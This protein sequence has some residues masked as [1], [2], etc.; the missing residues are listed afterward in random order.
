MKYS[1][2]SLMIVV[3]LACVYL[4]SYSATLTPI[5]V[6]DEGW[7][8]MVVSGQR[9][10]RF[11]IFDGVLQFVFLPVIWCDRVVRPGYWEKFSDF[12]K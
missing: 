12:D 9:E 2:R 8:G 10:P 11:R 5:V 4:G 6:V 1:L 7:H 3:T